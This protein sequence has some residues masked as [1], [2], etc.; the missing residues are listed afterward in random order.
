MFSPDGTL[1][2]FCVRS[3]PLRGYVQKVTGFEINVSK[4]LSG[5]E[6]GLR[7]G[8][9]PQSIHLGLSETAAVIGREEGSGVL[10]TGEERAAYHFVIFADPLRGRKWAGGMNRS[11]FVRSH[12]SLSISERERERER[13]RERERERERER[14]MGTEGKREKGVRER[15]KGCLLYTSDA[16]DDC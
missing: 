16:A 7:I 9:L 13:G 12:Q 4:R 3:S 1:I 11:S 10:G 8:F 2:S 6:I 14:G 5:T 15:E